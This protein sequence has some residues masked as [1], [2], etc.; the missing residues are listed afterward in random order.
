[1][2][3]AWIMHVKKYAKEHNIPYKDALKK[4]VSTYKKT[5]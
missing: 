5:K 1:M 4:A 3:S 2:A